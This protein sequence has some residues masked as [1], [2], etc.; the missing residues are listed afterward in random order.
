MIN[1][2]CTCRCIRSNSHNGGVP[3]RRGRAP[4]P[5]RRTHM[6]SRRGSPTPRRR[7]LGMELR[8]LRE[9]AGLTIEQVAE[10]LSCSTSK[11]SRIETGHTGVTPR[12]V[13]E[14]IDAYDI[15]PDNVELLLDIASEA[16]QKGW[17]QLFGA[18]LTGA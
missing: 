11:I 10:R 9:R 6:T 13:R 18:V 2:R 7:Q 4:D 12:D 17:W 8:R 5:S 1:A 16:R 14:F 15:G 3:P